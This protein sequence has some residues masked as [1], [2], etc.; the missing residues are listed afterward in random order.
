[1]SIAGL[2]EPE[3]LHKKS[4]HRRNDSSELDV[5]AATR[6]FSGANEVSGYKDATFAQKIMMREDHRHGWRGG[7]R[8]S[9]D[10]PIMRSSF[11]SQTHMTEKQMTKEKKYKQPSSPGAKL[12]SFLNSLFNQTS[13][14]KKKSSYSTTQSMKDE[15]LESPFGRRRRRS[16]ISHFQSSSTADSK[17]MHSSSSSGFRTPPPYTDPTKT[18]RD[19]RSVSD[20]KQV[21]SLPKYNNIGHVKYT[22][23]QNEVCSDKRSRDYAWL[24]HDN[25]FKLSNGF[26]GKQKNFGHGFSEKYMIS[27]DKYGSE[28]KEFKR[29]DGVDDGGESDSSSDLFELK[30]H[31]LGYFSSGRPVYETA[32][33]DGIKRGAPIS[34]GPT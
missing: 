27:T 26:S 11:P 30:N 20:H 1:M 33:M 19:L 6:Y 4:F 25:K 32:H 7:R 12:A 18:Y 31:D 9:L 15:D 22:A 23:L 29:F 13:S 3:K 8:I 2:S 14:K 24:D 28:E 16:S 21:V 10:M 5:F 17:S 34:N